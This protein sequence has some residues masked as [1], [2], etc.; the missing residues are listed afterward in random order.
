MFKKCSAQ[1]Y[2]SHISVA[3]LKSFS[4]A[5][6]I[7]IIAWL[8]CLPVEIK[9]TVV[10]SQNMACSGPANDMPMIFINEFCLC[11]C[12]CVNWCVLCNNRGGLAYLVGMNKLMEMKHLPSFS[13]FP[14]TLLVTCIFC[15]S[16]PFE[17]PISNLSVSLLGSH[18]SIR[19]LYI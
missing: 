8:L 13:A 11:V 7:E 1:F 17:P 18:Y 14:H 19:Y 2:K 12:V 16:K 10:T 4:S 9:R 15:A 6:R 5:F 3:K